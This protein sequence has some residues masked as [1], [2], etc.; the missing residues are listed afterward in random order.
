MNRHRP[1][2]SDRWWKWQHRLAPYLFVSP[3]ILLFSIFTLYPMFRS[4]LLSFY[5]TA[6]PRHQVFVGLDNYRYLLGHDLVFLL[7][8]ANTTGFTIAFLLLQVPLSLGL[9][10]LLQSRHVKFRNFF[11]F[12]FFSSYLVGQVFVGVIFFQIFGARGL[13]NSVLGRI[14]GH[15]VTV[16]WLTNPAM[17]LPSVLIAS[18]WLASG[19]GMIYFLAALQAVDRELYEAAEVDGAGRWQSFL[20]ITLPGI[21]PM[22]VYLILVGTIY[23][24]Q[25]FEL[26]FVLLQGSGPNGRGLTIVMYLFFM[27]FTSGDLGYASAIGW[28]LMLILLLVSLAQIKLT[29]A[30]AEH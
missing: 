23:G 15:S 27:G 8:A 5:K 13:L 2:G 12:S 25:L 16:P 26:P 29:R 1:A 6:G 11:R 20:H 22:M 30:T 10:L 19:Y 21:R 18:L 28:T 4:L 3:F 14:A 9:A 24:V 7:A 17:V